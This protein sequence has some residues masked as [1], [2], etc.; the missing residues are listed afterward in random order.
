MLLKTYI[1]CYVTFSDSSH[2]LNLLL[3]D[4]R[5]FHRDGNQ[6]LDQ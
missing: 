5:G 4:I 6:D 2:F 3:V 1:F